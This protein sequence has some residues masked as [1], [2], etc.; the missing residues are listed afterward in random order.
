MNRQREKETGSKIIKLETTKEEDELI[1]K[2][3]VENEKGEI[4]SKIVISILEEIRKNSEEVRQARFSEI[5]RDINDSS[6]FYLRWGNK[7][8]MTSEEKQILKEY[9]STDNKKQKQEDKLPVSFIGE[10]FYSISTSIYKIG[11]DP[12]NSSCPQFISDPYEPTW[13]LARQLR[14]PERCFRK[15]VKGRDYCHPPKNV[16]NWQLGQ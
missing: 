15:Y 9:T 8:G 5:F 2:R 3:K 13:E 7:F 14:R 16:G 4:A 6:L 12:I 10:D 11:K 1:K